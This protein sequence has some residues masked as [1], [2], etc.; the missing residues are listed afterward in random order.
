MD[1]E[2]VYSAAL[3]RQGLGMVLS[4]A[5][6][7]STLLAFAAEDSLHHS[8]VT[9]LYKKAQRTRLPIRRPQRWHVNRSTQTS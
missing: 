4:G 6:G 5:R 1:Y 9:A 3:E 7:N 2:V 8:E